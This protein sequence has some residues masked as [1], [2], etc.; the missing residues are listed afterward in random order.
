MEDVERWRQQDAVERLVAAARAWAPTKGT[1]TSSQARQAL[2]NA[3]T[4]LAG[5]DVEDLHYAI[6]EAGRETGHAEE[7]A[8]HYG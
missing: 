1:R 4:A 7:R 6:H 8:I 5:V 3:V 2:C